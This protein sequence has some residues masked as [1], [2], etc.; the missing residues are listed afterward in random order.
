MWY[1]GLTW[2]GNSASPLEVLQ[3]RWDTDPKAH[4]CVG[5]RSAVGWSR[6]FKDFCHMRLA[7]GSE[8]LSVPKLCCFWLGSFAPLLSMVSFWAFKFS[9]IWGET[10]QKG[11]PHPSRTT[12]KLS[13]FWERRCISWPLLN[14]SFF[15]GVPFSLFFLLQPKHATAHISNTTWIKD[16]CRSHGWGIGLLATKSGCW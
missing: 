16:R 13:R 12:R 7:I 4:W 5:W 1:P 3:D 6:F 11:H 15:F 8:A 10:R 2:L 9:S 14:P